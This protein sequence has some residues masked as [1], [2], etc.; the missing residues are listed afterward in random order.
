MQQPT[1]VRVRVV[2]QEAEERTV[3]LVAMRPLG[4]ADDVEAAPEIGGPEQSKASRE[5]PRTSIRVP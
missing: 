4:G 5:L 3:R 2:Q 1:G